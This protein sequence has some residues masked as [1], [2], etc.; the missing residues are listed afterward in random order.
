[1]AFPPDL[2]LP[3]VPKRLLSSPVDAYSGTPDID[4]KIDS[5]GG[6]CCNYG[7]GGVSHPL[8]LNLASQYF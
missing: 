2:A 7:G 8:A 5:E 3:L 6:Y 1:M 4:P